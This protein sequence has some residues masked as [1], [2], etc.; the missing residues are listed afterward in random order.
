[1]HTV[2]PQLSKIASYAGYTAQDVLLYFET[3]SCMVKELDAKDRILAKS[4][5]VILLQTD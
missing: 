1:M 2:Y 5:Q 4:Q 3:R